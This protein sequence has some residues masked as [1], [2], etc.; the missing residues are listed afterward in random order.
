MRLANRAHQKGSDDPETHLLCRHPPAP[1]RF[2]TERG[3]R[4]DTAALSTPR[5]RFTTPTWPIT[6]FPKRSSASTQANC[7]P[8]GRPTMRRPTMVTWLLAV[9][10]AACLWSVP[11]G[12]RAQAVAGPEL[13]LDPSLLPALP[14]VI[15]A[16]QRNRM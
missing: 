10:V 12:A 7:P 2:H 4:H 16:S 1:R 11:S 6:A 15:P 13:R 9:L 3:L 14:P 5:T 8:T